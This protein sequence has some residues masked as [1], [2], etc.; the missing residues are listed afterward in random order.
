MT[1]INS[2]F[3]KLHYKNTYLGLTYSGVGW[4]QPNMGI[5]RQSCQVLK[6][7]LILNLCRE[8]VIC[9]ISLN[10]PFFLVD[11]LNDCQLSTLALYQDW[12]KRKY[13]LFGRAIKDGALSLYN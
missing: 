7:F 13:I 2:L 10:F 8:N 4:A 9:V 12:I 1:L 6:H 5:I 11:V 3:S